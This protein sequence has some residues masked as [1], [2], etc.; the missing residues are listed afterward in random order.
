M[1]KTDVKP[2]DSKKT[3]LSV[4]DIAAVAAH[5][6]IKMKTRVR[7]AS[8]K[9]GVLPERMA[10]SIF[11]Q[12][13]Q[14]KSLIR[15]REGNTLFNIKAATKNGGVLQ[16]LNGDT[17]NNVINNYVIAAQAAY[18]MGFDY[19]VASTKDKEV[20]QQ[21][22]VISQRNPKQF[23]FGESPKKDAVVLRLGAPRKGAK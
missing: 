18:K 4:T 6:N 22:K 13:M 8:K 14:D 20:C 21:L 10:Y 19:V 9:A 17:K 5:E 11:M 3:V 16:V 23:Q 1:E 2:I 7:F 12:Q 15:I